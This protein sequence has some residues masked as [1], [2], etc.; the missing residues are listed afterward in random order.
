MTSLSALWWPIASFGISTAWLVVLSNING[1][2]QRDLATLDSN[3][4][5]VLSVAFEI[6]NL[7][8]KYYGSFDSP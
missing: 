5:S 6:D 1:I 2:R 8:Y 7:T 3:V 4:C